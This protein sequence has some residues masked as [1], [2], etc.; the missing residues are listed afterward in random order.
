MYQVLIV[1]DEY[2]AQNKIC[3]MIN[4]EDYDFHICGTANNGSEAISFIAKNHVDVIFTDICM[5]SMNGVEL[6]KYINV[7]APDIKVVIM[8]SYSDFEY[9]KECFAEGA[10]DYVL[11]HLLTPDA[12]T[13]ILDKLTSK[14]LH[15]KNSYDITYN[16]Y[17]E[18][19][20]HRQHIIDLICRKVSDSQVFGAVVAVAQVSSHI[21]LEFV[22]SSD[23][24]QTFYRHI[25]NTMSQ[26]LKELDGFVIFQD[27]DS[28]I[29]IFLP[30][31]DKPEAEIMHEIRDY[32]QQIN[33][34]IKKFFD[35]SLKWGISCLS[36][37]SYSLGECYDE[38]LHMLSNKP[39]VGKKEPDIALEF[40]SLSTDDEK[41]IIAAVQSMNKSTVSLALERIFE[42]IPQQPLSVNI[43]VSEL[44]TLANKLCTEFNIDIRSLGN[45]LSELNLAVNNNCTKD[46]ILNRNKKLFHSIVNACSN[47]NRHKEKYSA[48]VQDYIKENYSSDIS[49]QQIANKIGINESY[50]STVFKEETGE[51][52]SN[53]LANFRIEK[54]KELLE[55]NVDIKYLY[56]AVGFK[57]YNYFFVTFKKIVGCTPRQYKASHPKKRP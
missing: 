51:T 42:H 37:P 30:F 14:Y 11:K 34:S 18:T 40:R 38:A 50:L 27:S 44:I 26:N 3:T 17:V 29:V 1:D 7:N 8:S 23:E 33:Y 25:I 2:L 47:R 39:I 57:S 16:E 15:H 53:Y 49:L 41:Q 52:V 5:P 35:L 4:W 43:I 24:L 22:H 13:A 45:T 20:K 32:I 12:L 28:N 46:E 6:T 31:P 48:L 10:C 21:P 56:S 55:K 54:A 9:V 19:K 36:S